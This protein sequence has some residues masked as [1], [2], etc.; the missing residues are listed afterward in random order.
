VSLVSDQEGFRECHLLNVKRKQEAEFWENF[1]EQGLGEWFSP[2]PAFAVRLLEEAYALREADAGAGRYGS[3]RARIL[4]HW[5]RPEAAPGPEQ[6]L[7]PLTPE[8]S[9]RYLEESRKLA[10]HPLFLAWMPGLAELAPWMEKLQEVQASPLVLSD[11][12]RQGR[13]EAILD[14]ATQTLYSPES[15]P[16]WRRRLLTM[17]YYL[18]LRGSKEEAR[19]AQ[20]AAADLAETDRGLLKGENPFLKALVQYSLHLAR[21]HNKPGEAATSSGL[22]A[23]STQSLLFRR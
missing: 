14:E 20:A 8:E 12:Q 1:R 23:P 17:A 19:A 2:P 10:A 16:S 22:V 13:V 15:R 6:V 3:L 11:Q 18:D 7:P 5:G 21:E 4:P 9:R